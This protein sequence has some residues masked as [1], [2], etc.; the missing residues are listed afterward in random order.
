MANTTTFP[1]YTTGHVDGKPLTV[2]SAP[3]TFI[4]WA[5]PTS[6]AYAQIGSKDR[7]GVGAN[8]FRIELHAD[9]H[10]AL[11]YT[12]VAGHKGPPGSA[13]TNGYV[14]PLTSPLP[15]PLNQSTQVAVVH[16]DVNYALFINGKLVSTYKG[17]NAPHNNDLDFRIGSRYPPGSGDGA[18]DPFPG[19]INDGQFYSGVALNP[20][21]IAYSYLHPGAVLGSEGH[22]GE[23]GGTGGIAFADAATNQVATKVVIEYDVSTASIYGVRSLQVWHGNT[24]GTKHGNT[25]G[26]KP[27]FSYEF[28]LAADEYIVGAVASY[29]VY[30]QSIQFITSKNRASPFF[31][32]DRSTR[33]YL[34]LPPKTALTGFT[35][36]AGW[37]IDDI[38]LN[39]TPL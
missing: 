16:D 31:G 25:G 39:G 37:A 2:G 26:V 30:V 22:S 13:D 23:V 4:A 6:Y 24:P 34:A 28:V 10:V 19:T 18:N 11:A 27:E 7:S 17:T 36:R 5:N 35:G 32:R 33:A 9:G 15:I 20:D 38:Q 29:D 8:Q 12:G 14:S 1:V 3:W 21:Q